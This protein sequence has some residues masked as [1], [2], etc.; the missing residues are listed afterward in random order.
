MVE[1]WGEALDSGGPAGSWAAVTMVLEVPSGQMG[2][3]S[4]W[5]C[6][7]LPGGGSQAAAAL[8]GLWVIKGGKPGS[9]SFFLYFSFVLH[10]PSVFVFHE[11]PFYV[12]FHW[13]G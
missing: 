11:M 5:S 8:Q 4:I 3:L 10:Q 1:V 7:G 12:K 9:R 2:S 6:N 13:R